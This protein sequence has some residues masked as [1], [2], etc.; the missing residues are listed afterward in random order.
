MKSFKMF[1]EADALE[2]YESW[3]EYFDEEQYSMPKDDISFFVKK[4]NLSYER[5]GNIVKFYEGDLGSVWT[6]YDPSDETFDAVAFNDD[7][8][9]NHISNMG[10]SEL[11][12][13]LGIE[14]ESDVYIGCWE[15]TIRDFQENPVIVYH[16]TTE[17]GLEEIQESGDLRG[18]YGTGLTNRSAFGIFT[19]LDPE[20]HALGTYG[21]IQLSI[22]LDQFKESEK[23]EKLELW[24]EP[25]V[26]EHALVEAMH[27]KLELP[28][29][30]NEVPSDMSPFT[31][32][33]G[34]TIPLKFVTVEE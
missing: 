2:E 32:I 24:P 4:F 1:L 10:E 31:V 16:H 34:H 9:S 5:Y 27:A 13:H 33:V 19:T 28:D 26:L 12:E 11:V 21:D 7:D 20:E 6:T 18:V 14:D 8:M 3:D 25:D 15:A 23:L 30:Y 29:N 17:E 22:R